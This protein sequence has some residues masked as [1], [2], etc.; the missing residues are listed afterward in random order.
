MNLEKEIPFRTEEGYEYLVRF[1][2]F[3]SNGINYEIPIVDVSIILMSCD[4]ENNSM[5]TLNKFTDIIDDYLQCHNVVLYY[6]C[7]TAP[8][9]MRA[10]RNEK[11]LPQEFRSKLFSSMFNQKKFG[12]YILKEIR[13]TDTE[14]GDHFISLISN[15]NNADKI[16]L[17]ESDL[18]NFNK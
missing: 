18:Q 5:K 1:A 4:I 9:K 15:L 17:I 13:I 2:E 10:T 8:I 11:L 7:D 3:S 12:E 6:Y 14:R 16:Q